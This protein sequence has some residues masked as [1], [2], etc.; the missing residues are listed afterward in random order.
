MENGPGL[1]MYVLL[2]IEI[3]HCYV[4][5]QYRSVAFFVAYFLE[6]HQTCL[7]IRKCVFVF[8]FAFLGPLDQAQKETDCYD[9]WLETP[10]SA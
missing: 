4:R 10:Y 1:K 7:N 2:K 8:L 9:V 3:F 5:L 6:V